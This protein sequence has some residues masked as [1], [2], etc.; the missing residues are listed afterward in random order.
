M[1]FEYFDAA[2]TST[3][4]GVFIPISDLP[5]LTA[6][7]LAAG[8]SE[9]AKQ[10]RATF[11][12]IKSIYGTLSP[13][14]F[15]KLGF[16]VANT[17]TSAGVGLK[18]RSYSVSTQYLSDIENSTVT[19]IPVPASGANSG[20]GDFAFVD[21]F[22]NAVKVAAAGAVSDAGVV[23]S[24]ADLVPYG[25]PAHASLDIT[26]GQDNRFY[27]AALINWL[28]DG[29]LSVRSAS[30]AS[31]I[32]TVSRGTPANAIL[33]AEATAATD[34]TTG[35]DA[36]DLSKLFITSIT[37]SLTIQTIDDIDSETFDVN[38]VTA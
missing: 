12:T 25:S 15:S 13:S 30:T 27:L 29:G 22:P 31:A 26:A 14:A 1:S 38:V 5:G 24:T 21:L 19:M 9:A 32:A 23:I 33:A 28:V 34:P 6:A 37:Y 3:N 16:T 18:N 36:A 7:E 2:G 17:E 11:S 10:A 8:E 35:I 20:V 4:D